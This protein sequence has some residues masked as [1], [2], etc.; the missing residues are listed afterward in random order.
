MSQLIEKTT[1]EE[2]LNKILRGVKYDT[3]KLRYDLLPVEP[4]EEVIK[5]LTLGAEKYSA[6]NWKKVKPYDTRYYNAALRHIQ[7]WRR[8]ERLD[9]ES[10]L[11]HLAHAV[12]CLLFIL[13]KERNKS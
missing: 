6:E 5:V 4:I 10:K 8:G 2:E 13:W 12:C 11:P 7:A 3:G 9:E 1:T